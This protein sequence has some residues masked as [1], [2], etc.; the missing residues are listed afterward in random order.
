LRFFDILL[1]NKHMNEPTSVTNMTT[2]EGNRP[3][4][5]TNCGH[6]IN[7][8]VRASVKGGADA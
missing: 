5:R 1:E 6:E 7:Q 8:D 2:Y 4:L 3:L